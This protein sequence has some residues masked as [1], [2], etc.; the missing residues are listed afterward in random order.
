M[1]INKKSIEEFRTLYQEEFGKYL[2]EEDALEMATRLIELYQLIY[3]PL[4]GERGTT[5]PSEH[6]PDSDASF[7]NV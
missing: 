1:P 2:S 6:R 3:R 5:Q 7:P 4:P